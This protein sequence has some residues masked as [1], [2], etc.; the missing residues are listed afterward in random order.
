MWRVK[1]RKRFN[2]W[3]ITFTGVTVTVLNDRL[4]NVY[5]SPAIIQRRNIPPPMTILA[6]DYP[7]PNKKA[8]KISPNDGVSPKR[9]GPSPSANSDFRN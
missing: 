6:P 4:F 1:S 9:N 2:A 5:D 3:E 8:S 7:Q